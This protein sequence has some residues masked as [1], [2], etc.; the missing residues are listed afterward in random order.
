MDDLNLKW[1]KNYPIK[2]ICNFKGQ[3]AVG[4]CSYSQKIAMF[5]HD[6]RVPK[7]IQD[8]IIGFDESSEAYGCEEEDRC[9]N[10]E[11]EY[12]NIDIKQYLQITGIKPTPKAILEL[13]NGLKDLNND[14]KSENLV[15]FEKYE[16]IDFS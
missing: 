12:C 10:F 13:K 4:I 15:P 8:L 5:A 9:C 2:W 14:L 1:A 6:N 11:C 7:L 3:T 16:I